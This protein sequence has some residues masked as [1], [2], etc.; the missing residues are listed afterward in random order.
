MTTLVFRSN[1]TSTSSLSCVPR[2]TYVGQIVSGV[3]HT[4]DFADEDFAAL[5]PANGWNGLG[6]KTVSTLTCSAVTDCLSVFLDSLKVNWLPN[7]TYTFQ[8]SEN[9]MYDISGQGSPAISINYT[10]NPTPSYSAD[11]AINSVSVNNAYVAL[12]FDRKMYPKTGNFYFYQVE[13]G[14]TLLKTVSV[15]SAINANG[16]VKIDVKGLLKSGTTYYVLADS[17]ALVD[18]DGLNWP[19]I[20]SATEFRYQSAG[21]PY[22]H[23]FISYEV[24]LGT[25]TVRPSRIFPSFVSVMSATSSVIPIGS[26]TSRTTARFNAS[27]TSTIL[28]GKRQG[29]IARLNVQST[30]T[31]IAI[32]SPKL[33]SANLYSTTTFTTNAVKFKGIIA[34]LEASSTINSTLVKVIRTS[35]LLTSVSSVSPIAFNKYRS[36]AATII[37]SG[38]TITITP[39]IIKSTSV[40]LTCT[41]SMTAT[42]IN[43]GIQYSYDTSESSIFDISILDSQYM[44][45]RQAT[46]AGSYRYTTISK[47]DYINNTVTNPTYPIYTNYENYQIAHNFRVAAG[48]SSIFAV[49]DQSSDS[50]SIYNT[51]DMSQITTIYNPDSNTTNFG[52]QIVVKNNYI[53]ISAPGNTE[54]VGTGKVYIYNATTYSL[55]STINNPYNTYGAFNFGQRIEC[56]GSVIAITWG[57]PQSFNYARPAV[58]LYNMDGSLNK[59]ITFSGVLSGYRIDAKDIALNSTYVLV[60]QSRW[61]GYS[62][63]DSRAAWIL[64]NIST[65]NVVYSMSYTPPTGTSWA[66]PPLGSAIAMDETNF[67]IGPGSFASDNGGL[68]GN[69]TIVPAKMYRLSDGQLI[70]ERFIGVPEILNNYYFDRVY[71]YKLSL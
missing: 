21:E 63:T 40:S 2:Q 56:N 47:L 30:I 3:V 28:A 57:N 7:T 24:S 66:M 1:L 61:N 70:K 69:I 68:S 37:T 65:G 34:R 43:S 55:L 27:S 35:A 10:T 36:L 19:G 18:R 42:Y 25:L 5:P 45:I 71:V 32:K 9:F 20:S 22:F 44:L 64:Y 11:P 41:S 38:G 59:E 33:A 17:T 49:K 54:T 4:I 51:S 15:T 52:Q 39:N 29:V 26:K 31:V 14:T 23:D 50:V 48:N 58:I 13:G 62:G 16:L 67:I 6:F 12:Q 8:I 46:Q 60:G 53:I